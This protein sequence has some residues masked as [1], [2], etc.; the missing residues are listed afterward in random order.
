VHILDL[1]DPAYDIS[2]YG[3]FVVDLPRLV[4]SSKSLDAAISAFVAGFNTLRNRTLSKVT[5]LDRYVYA[6]KTLRESMNDASQVN[7][8]DNM[9]SIYLIAICQVS[10]SPAVRG[11]VAL[12]HVRNGSEILLGM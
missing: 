5:A 11:F 4:G 7:S 12:I 2:T 9:C 1:N 8:V 3:S 10:D 6:L